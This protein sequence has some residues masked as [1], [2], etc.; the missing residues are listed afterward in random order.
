[1][2]VDYMEEWKPVIVDKENKIYFRSKEIKMEK[3]TTIQK[4]EKLN[5]VYALD[6][7]GNGGAN[8]LYAI[9]SKEVGID[10]NSIFSKE[11]Q[12]QN[13]ARKESGSIHGV[14]DTDLLEIVRHRIQCFQSGPFATE[15]NQKA[16]E[17]IEIALMYLNRRV[18][19][20]IERNV[21][22]TNNK[23]VQDVKSST[24]MQGSRMS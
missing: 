20:R 24:R 16:L 22:G 21:L 10:G 6:I 7:K 15:Y 23:Q 14:L 1:M 2:E 12:F 8:H 4:R 3:I 9:Y 11:I 18:E 5:D 19:D 13:G 17:H